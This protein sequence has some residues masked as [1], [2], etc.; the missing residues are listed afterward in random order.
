[1]SKTE[2]V[3]SLDQMLELVMS[4]KGV[5][6]D[7]DIVSISSDY[8]NQYNLTMRL[9]DELKQLRALADRIGNN[10]YYKKHYT[11]STFLNLEQKVR[12]HDYRSCDLCDNII[13]KTQYKAHIKRNC[14]LD[15]R[16]KKEMERR[17]LP[18][19][20]HFNKQVQ[21]IN[22]HIVQR[23]DVEQIVYRV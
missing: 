3:Q 13:K 15:G 23:R 6:S 9:V 8:M 1:M 11:K 16:L 18:I 4:S 17:Q 12:S 2:Y 5:I 19:Y 14:C 20:I 22:R 10:S 21:L 7:K